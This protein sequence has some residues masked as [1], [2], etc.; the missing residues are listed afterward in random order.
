MNAPYGLIPLG[1]FL[2]LLYG[3]SFLFSRLGI[4]STPAHRKIWNY[5]LLAVFLVTAGLGVLMAVQVNYWLEILG[6]KSAENPL[7][8]GLGMSLI[9]LFTFVGT[10]FFQAAENASGP[11]RRVHLRGTVS[12]AAAPGGPGASLRCRLLRRG[13]PNAFNPGIPDVV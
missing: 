8:F 13:G 6:R 5:A 3:I 10:L 11:D 9:G 4:L 12:T 7:N 2:A 1:L